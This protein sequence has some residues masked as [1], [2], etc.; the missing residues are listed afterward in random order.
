MKA[1]ILAAGYFGCG[2]LGDDAILLAFRD[3]CDASGFE[4][5]AL[6]GAPELTHRNFGVPAV[7]RKEMARVKQAIEECDALVFPGGSIFQDVT[8]VKSVAYYGHLIKLAKKSGKKVVLLGQGVG[9]VTSYFGKKI[10]RTALCAADGITVRDAETAR[11]LNQLGVPGT[12]RTTADLA[13]LLP[14]P[15]GGDDVKFGVGDMKSIGLAPRP[16]GKGTEMVEVF[17]EVARQLFQNGY[18]PVLIEMDT[19]M[20]KP[21]LDAI[22][23]SQ[24]GKVPG[25]RKI[26]H[27]ADLQRRIARMEALVAVRLHAGILAAT[28][29][30]P[31]LMIAYDP[32]VSAFAKDSGLP[33]IPA[34]GLNAARIVEGLMALIK[35][36]EQ[37][38]E[39]LASRRSE[40]QKLA[41]GNIEFLDACL[42]R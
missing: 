2:N 35:N 28:V 14:P 7:P 8:S 34:A 12:I 20:D 32:K 27:P 16:H 19:V 37:A 33:S 41:R 4:L 26:Q 10:A 40:M 31:S 22:E 1:R 25:V 21:I 38:A 29:A 13:F 9:P 15:S 24:G 11:T 42:K 3:A 23:K 39:R 6:S 18:M 17:G 5:S 36:R 30:V